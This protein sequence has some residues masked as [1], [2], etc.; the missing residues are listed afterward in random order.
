MKLEAKFK[1][2][3]GENMMDEGPKFT[4]EKLEELRDIVGENYEY[5]AIPF[6]AEQGPMDGPSAKPDVPPMADLRLV[7]EKIDADITQ[8]DGLAS[9]YGICGHAE[10]A[11][12]MQHELRSLRLARSILVDAMKETASHEEAGKPTA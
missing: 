4:L 9:G 7:I 8:T 6:D 1:A 5:V 10:M 12:K 11:E 3:N 2:N